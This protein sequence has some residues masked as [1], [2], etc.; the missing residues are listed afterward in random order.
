[1]AFT[2]TFRRRLADDKLQ[3]AEEKK[4]R[5][6]AVSTRS[7]L[8]FAAYEANPE[9]VK[10][11]F[12]V[13]KD[14]HRGPVTITVNPDYPTQ[15][16]WVQKDVTTDYI[17]TNAYRLAISVDGEMTATAQIIKRIMNEVPIKQPFT[18]RVGPIYYA[19]S[20]Y[21][22]VDTYA[23]D[24]LEKGLH[25]FTR[26]PQ[27]FTPTIEFLDSLRRDLLRDPVHRATPA[28]PVTIS[29]DAAQHQIINFPKQTSLERVG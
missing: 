26:E 10:S 13:K 28:K 8:R 11:A 20:P 24:R 7:A 18:L 17:E 1:M 19:T 15:A 29:G 25:S 23:F 9:A 21:A 16:T 5:E 12:R 3:E 6:A 4:L 27:P 14:T 22:S 2:E